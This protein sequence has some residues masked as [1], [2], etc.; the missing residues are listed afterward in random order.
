[1]YK[2]VYGS[3]KKYAHWISEE[4]NADLYEISKISIEKLKEYDTIVYGG[5]LYAVGIAGLSKIKNNFNKLSEKTIVV[6]SVGASPAN[7]TALEDIKNKN[8]STQMKDKVS[9]FHLRGG[10]NYKK[11]NLVHKLL[12]IIMKKIIE[13]KKQEDL[14]NDEKGMLSIYNKPVDWTNK[15][16][17]K[18]IVQKV[19]QEI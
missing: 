4:I 12:M 2:S 9:F 6:F 7:E 5:G 10:F 18:P 11:L 1:M 16:N 8:L 13:A 19:R 15:N 17:I 3:T 14:T